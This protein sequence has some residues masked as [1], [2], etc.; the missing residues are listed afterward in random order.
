MSTHT[1]ESLD[2]MAESFVQAIQEAK[3][4]LSTREALEIVSKR[5]NIVVGSAKTGLTYAKA[6]GL[7]HLNQSTMK[8]SII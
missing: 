2:R 1:S 6:T 3:E 4:P 5:L 8:L 7:I